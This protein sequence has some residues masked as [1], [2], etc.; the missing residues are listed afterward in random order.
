MT[1]ER[2][3]QMEALGPLEAC[4]DPPLLYW[5][6]IRRKFMPA[7]IRLVAALIELGRAGPEDLCDRL[8]IEAVQTLMSKIA[9]LRRTFA[10]ADIP[11]RIIGD[12]DAPGRQLNCYRLEIEI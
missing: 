12:L 9:E 6:G 10:I 3:I 4:A 7:Q 11:V 8:G 1:R 5:S 2:I